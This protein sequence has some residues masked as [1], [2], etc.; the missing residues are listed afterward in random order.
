LVN[1]YGPTECTIDAAF[2]RYPRDHHPEVIPIGRPIANT[3]IYILD[4]R[5]Q[6]VPVGVPGELYIASD[7]IARGYLNRPELTAERFVPDPFSREPGARLYRTGDLGR[8]RSDGNIEFLGRTDHQVKIRGYRI[9]L[10]EIEAALR[11]CPGVLQAAVTVVDGEPAR[12][13]GYVVP[14]SLQPAA[15]REAL[16]ARLPAYMVPSAFVALDALPTLPNGKLDRKALPA[17][18]WG[19]QPGADYE[20]PQGDCEQAL[21]RIWSQVLGIDRIGRHD[22]FFELGGHSLLVV[23]MVQ[24]ARQVGLDTSVREVFALPRLSSLARAVA[25][26]AGDGDGTPTAAVQAIAENRIPPGCT[27]IRPDMLPLIE[28]AQEDIDRI[29]AAVPGGAP[30]VQ[31]IYPLAPLQE[32]IL[33]HH[34]LETEGDTY[35]IREI[36]EFDSPAHLTAFL[37]AFQ[38]VIDRHDNLRTALLWER[39]PQALQVVLRDAPLPIHPLDCASLEAAVELLRDVTDSTRLRLDLSRAPLMAAYVARTPGAQTCHLGLVYHHVIG[40]QV[41]LEQMMEE[42]RAVMTGRMAAL[43]PPVPYREFVAR[44]RETPAAQHEA[45]FRELLG[46]LDEPTL[47]FDVADL[48]ADHAPIE[49]AQRLL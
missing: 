23:A 14:A 18:D 12:L 1:T 5:M 17:P 33:Y 44:T 46:D 42:V 40:D 30:N 48:R 43:K 47:P 38:V 10:D 39:L 22:D 35:L 41:S 3:R 28:L 27:A 21:A 32:G 2:F 26:R 31:D 15:L 6:P 37:E 34:R 19:S 20:P 11:D 25:A 29:V 9:E 7:G 16:A 45:Y 24:G 4:E 13:A 8:F 49:Q 36:L